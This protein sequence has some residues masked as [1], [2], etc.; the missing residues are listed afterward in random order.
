M[1]QTFI[2]IVPEARYSPVGGTY[3][4]YEQLNIDKNNLYLSMGTAQFNMY[5]NVYQYTFTDIRSLNG[6]WDH[7]NKDFFA[8][9]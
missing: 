4:S 8:I 1:D 9:N 3:H 6:I 5:D 7:S 2:S